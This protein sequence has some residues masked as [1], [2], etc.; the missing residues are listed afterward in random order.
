MCRSADV[1]GGS[2]C[3]ARVRGHNSHTC[4]FRGYPH[5]Y[6]H[7]VRRAHSPAPSPSFVPRVTTGEG[8]CVG[9]P[10]STHRLFHNERGL[11]S[12]RVQLG[13]TRSSRR[14]NHDRRR[15]TGRS[16]RS[17]HVSYTCCSSTD[18]SLYRVDHGLVLATFSVKPRGY[19][20]C[21]EACCAYPC[22]RSK[23]EQGRRYRLPPHL[24]GRCSA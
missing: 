3:G 22:G 21:L 17:R 14:S 16:N 6:T 2:S 19:A 4:R 20:F 5:T 11:F 13:T 18:S 9:Y 23:A 1:C 7:C 10:G 24:G 15:G 8:C 12:P